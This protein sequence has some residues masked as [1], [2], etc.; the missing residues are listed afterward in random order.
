MN[1]ALYRLL[2]GGKTRGKIFA[3]DTCKSW[4]GSVSSDHLIDRGTVGGRQIAGALGQGRGG[5]HTERHSL[6][7]QE[8]RVFRFGFKGVAKG[9]SKV[10]NASQVA[11]AFVG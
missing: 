2:I 11:F 9:M 8:A 3:G 5:S 7:M 6:S 10:Q 4:D 1:L